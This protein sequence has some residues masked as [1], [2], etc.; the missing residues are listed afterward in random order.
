MA[1]HKTPF[2]VKTD[3]NTQL[4]GLAKQANSINYALWMKMNWL[5]S[6]AE[7][8]DRVYQQNPDSYQSGTMEKNRQMMENYYKLIGKM[9]LGF[10]QRFG[11]V[12]NPEKMN[13][14]IEM[15]LQP[16]LRDESSSSDVESEGGEMDWFHNNKK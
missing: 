3:L 1:G 12:V 4:C 8:F 2:E 16:W 14:E 9:D 15:P 11:P 13:I 10:Q 7:K 5:I 6:E